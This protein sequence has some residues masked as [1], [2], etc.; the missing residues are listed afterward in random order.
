M[1]GRLVHVELPA[2]D[3][4]RAIEFWSNLFGW[5]WNTE[6]MPGLS[7]HMTQ[8][9]GDPVAAVYASEQAGG[10][11][12]IYFSSEDIDGHVARVREL[13]GRAD[14]K[15]PIP[16]VGWFARCHDTEGNPFS[17]FQADEAVAPPAD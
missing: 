10:G 16:G 2:Q 5:E 6:E 4:R 13:G 12:I 15:Q 8:A 11:P 7:Y 17:L 3:D 14:D 9:G 1:A